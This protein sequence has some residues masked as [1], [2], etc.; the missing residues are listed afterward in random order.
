[1]GEKRLK[2]PFL[3]TGRVFLNIGFGENK[4]RIHNTRVGGGE[5]FSDKYI[6]KLFYKIRFF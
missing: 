4:C 3:N 6:R 5:E 2:I 1:M